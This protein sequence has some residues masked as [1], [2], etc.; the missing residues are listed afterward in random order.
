MSDTQGLDN[1]TAF[2]CAAFG[3]SDD[4][5]IQEGMTLRDWFAGQALAGFCSISIDEGEPLMG[6]A[7]TVAAAF[8]YA[9]A[10]LA[11]R[12]PKDLQP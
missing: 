7:D 4:S 8:N 2:P 9:D 5:W 11:A 10:M 6:A 3:P 12:A 1:P